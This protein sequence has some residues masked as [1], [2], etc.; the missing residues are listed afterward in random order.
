[1]ENKTNMKNSEL[2]FLTPATPGFE[3]K[4]PFSSGAFSFIITR[5]QTWKNVSH[6][7]NLISRTRAETRALIGRSEGGGGG[8]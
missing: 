3:E 7:R 5:K 6:A 4:A 1:M 2:S 8:E